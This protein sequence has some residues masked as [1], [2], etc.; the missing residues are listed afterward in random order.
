MP[1]TYQPRAS[2]MLPPV[3]AEAVGMQYQDDGHRVE[4]GTEPDEDGEV[5]LVIHGLTQHALLVHLNDPLGEPGHQEPRHPQTIKQHKPAVRTVP[6][7][8]GQKARGR[9]S[10]SL[11]VAEARTMARRRARDPAP[12]GNAI[13]K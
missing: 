12:G 13:G 5:K 10:V 9:R 7:P 11:A 2:A 6:R 4:I 3:W 1:R 8:H